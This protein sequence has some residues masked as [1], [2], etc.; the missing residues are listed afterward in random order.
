M[1]PRPLHRI[2]AR[3][4][5]RWPPRP[6]AGARSFA[7][8]FGIPIEGP[9]REDDFWLASIPQQA[10]RYGFPPATAFT[11][12]RWLQDGDTVSFGEQVMQVLHCPGHTPGHACVEINSEGEKAIITGDWI[13]INPKN[14]SAYDERNHVNLV[15]LS[16][17]SMPVVIEEEGAP[18]VE[19]KAASSG[20]SWLVP[21][22][23][24][25]VIGLAICN[26]PG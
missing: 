22:L 16:N 17:E 14:M 11:P 19:E 23:L 25:V 15:F 24:L 13:R 6:A 26:R 3:R 4:R 18:V 21:A 8:R 7:D 12:D 2:N 10:S 20:G 1:P 9:E 5:R